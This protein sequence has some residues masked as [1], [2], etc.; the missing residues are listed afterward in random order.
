MTE[1]PSLCHT[2]QDL[3]SKVATD[4]ATI[5]NA[6]DRP[7]AEARLASFIK[8]YSETQLKLAECAGINL[9]EGFTV[10]NFPAAHHQ[11]I[12][13]ANAYENLSSQIKRRIRVVGPF[14][15]EQSLLRRVT[16]VLI[17]ISET[18]ETGKA[19]LTLS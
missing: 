19:Y 2:K 18:W 14:P 9:P 3:K 5:F 7:H 10:F 8:S 4:I 1:G 6:D 16:G 13:T 12:R 17:K 15:N 11:K